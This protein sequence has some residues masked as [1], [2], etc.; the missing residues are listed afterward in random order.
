MTATNIFY[1]FVGF[2]YSPPLVITSGVELER[3][4]RSKLRDQMLFLTPIMT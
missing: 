4:L 1:N 3:I 2:R